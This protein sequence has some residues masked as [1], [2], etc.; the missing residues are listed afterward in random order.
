MEAIEGRQ[1][2]VAAGHITPLAQARYDRGPL[3]GS[4]PLHGMSL[5][6]GTTASQQAALSALLKAQQDPSSPD[7]RR[8]LTNE[9]FASEFGMTPADIARAASWLQSQGFTVDKV[10]VQPE[11]YLVQ[12]HGGAGRGGFPH[13]HPQ[14]LREWQDAVRQRRAGLG[15]ERPGR[16]CH[17]R[18]W[19][20]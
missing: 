15:S 5:D 17:S 2:S 1:D 20:N 19:L 7:Y 4:T 6:F 10:A 18:G 12:R 3:P 8:W 11:R 9:Q 14:I 16:Q 13:L